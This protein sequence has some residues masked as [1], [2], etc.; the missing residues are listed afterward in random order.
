MQPML[1]IRLHFQMNPSIDIIKTNTDN[2]KIIR[3]ETDLGQPRLSWISEHSKY[4][5]NI[6]INGIN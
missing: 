5:I 2:G 1:M 6:N 3:Q 4:I